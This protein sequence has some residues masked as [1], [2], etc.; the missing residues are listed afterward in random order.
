MTE[1]PS[2][3][4]NTS[5]ARALDFG[6]FRYHVDQEGKVLGA[7]EAGWTALQGAECGV[8]MSTVRTPGVPEYFILSADLT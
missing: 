8:L 3:A 4:R 6:P 7:S 5:T 2:A 1:M